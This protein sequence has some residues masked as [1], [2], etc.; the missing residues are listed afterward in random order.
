MQALQAR[1]SVTDT[2][3]VDINLTVE[4]TANNYL[5]LI[6]WFTMNLAFESSKHINIHVDCLIYV[7]KGPFGHQLYTQILPFTENTFTQQF[8]K[9][10]DCS[11]FRS[12]RGGLQIGLMNAN[13]ST[14]LWFIKSTKSDIH[15]TGKNQS[16]SIS[17][18]IYLTVLRAVCLFNYVRIISRNDG[19]YT[20]K[21]TIINDELSSNVN[22]QSHESTQ[23]HNR[24]KLDDN[25]STLTRADDHNCK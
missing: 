3:C 9:W 20:C 6:W 14:K 10:I 21:E 25:R 24:K 4:H 15:Q 18:Q 17:Y 16:I 8:T 5:L 22:T 19:V 11:V 12:N 13:Y 7:V 1:A 23:E 2:R